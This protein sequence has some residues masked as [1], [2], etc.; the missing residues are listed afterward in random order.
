MVTLL[1]FPYRWLPVV[2]ENLPALQVAGI[3]SARD[4]PYLNKPSHLMKT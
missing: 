2:T 1:W 4:V 3:L